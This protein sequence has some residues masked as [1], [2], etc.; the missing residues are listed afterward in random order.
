MQ[1]KYTVFI[2]IL[3]ACIF[4]T[5]SIK[6]QNNGNKLNFNSD[7]AINNSNNLQ[8]FAAMIDASANSLP[9]D[10]GGGILSDAK[11]KI[12]N[13]GPVINHKGVDYAPTVS[14]DGKTLYYV[15]N[16]KGSVL[17]KDDNPSHDF[18]VAKKNNRYDT[19]FTKPFNLDPSNL[20]GVAGVNTPL[21]E[22]AASIAGD[23]QSLYFT[24][25]NRPDGLGSCDIYKTTID[26]DK[27][28][29][30]VNLGKNINS[31]YFDSQPTITAGQ[32]RIYF[33]STRQGPNSDGEQTA[34]N[35]DIWYS[36]YDF[37]T[38]EWKPSQ[39]LTAINTK[40]SDVSPFIAADGV[41]LFFASDGHKPNF[42]GKD[43]YVT[44]L[45]PS[46]KTWTK[47]ENLGQPINTPQDE[48]FITLPGSGD[49]IYFSS[50]REDLKTQQGDLDVFMAFVPSFF[51]TVPLSGTVLDEC[52]NEFIPANITI[53]NPITNKV[54][55]D[56][57][58]KVKVEA[59][60]DPKKFNLLITSEMYGEAKDS[61]KYVNFEITAE[62]A[63]YGKK[64]IVQRIDKPKITKEEK[65]AGKKDEGIEV[66][67]TLG[68]RP[69]L[70]SDVSQGSFIQDAKKK[71]P[72]LQTYGGL[73][74]EEKISW[75]LYPLLSYVFFPK[76]SE[77]LPERYNLFENNESIGNF[78]DTTI[79]GGTLDKYYHVLNILAYRML[80]HPNA[81]ITI[82][83][84]ND[85][86]TPEEKGN[87]DLSKKRAQ[88]VFDYFKNIWKIG[89]D[90]MSMKA[91]N[92]PDTKSNPGDTLGHEENRRVE[93][94]CE[95]WEVSKPVFQKDPKTEPQPETM[96]FV[97]TN[98]IQD[99]LIASR[100]V[101]IMHGS[102]KWKVLNN[103][104]TADAKIKWDWKSEAGKYPKDEV[105]FIA[106]LIITSKGGK[107]CISDPIE[108][109]VMQV[110]S[111]KK[112][113]V[114]GA[115]SIYENYSL[116]LFK[117]N[118]SDPGPLND[119]IMNDYVYSR[120]QPSSVI[121][122][123]GHTDV[124]GL[125]ET[126]KK[127]SDNRAGTVNKGIQGKTKGKYASLKSKGVGEDNALYTNDLPEGR[128]Y[129][130][131]VQVLIT[132]PT[133]AYDNK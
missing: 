110:S 77:K 8:M 57:I 49:I 6:A 61:I 41:T 102:E 50:K 65:D 66:T 124:I 48:Q 30:P 18:W 20:L 21:N 80:K 33:V 72:K 27:W 88:V 47:P 100:R 125:F 43:F 64:T 5:G 90:R 56:T 89:E 26:G 98:G 75:D 52:T 3:I 106:K 109:P 16:R 91:N 103:N 15:S 76:G 129:N 68:Q 73:V 32:D 115:D 1:R 14:V 35:M 93:I 84:C 126:N 116:I 120:C 69:I 39:N 87:M 55:Y 83:G 119:K 63:K 112:I 34:E 7:L 24:G 95:E 113:T 10:G 107:E 81:K 74:M 44:R 28:G 86:V 59:G 71:D 97:L 118:S 12:I 22:G 13:L 25:C 42:G 58:P 105:S 82:T 92:F 99:E 17:D 9:Q 36:D 128:F 114:T 70:S 132:T 111:E 45:D 121:D 101:E 38:D 85:N 29:K 19:V 108:I 79:A 123:T 96:E 78:N 133:K 67:I 130:R 46:A 122:V 4:S 40:G 11:I 37:D 2:A 31:K 23:K 54:Y 127:L 62:N 131:T 117:F 53:R 104:V 94:K 60:D 51:K